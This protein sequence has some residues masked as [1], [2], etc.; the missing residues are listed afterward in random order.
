MDLKDCGK[1]TTEKSI[2][3]PYQRY[4]RYADFP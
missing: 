3:E 4:G 1:D 2:H